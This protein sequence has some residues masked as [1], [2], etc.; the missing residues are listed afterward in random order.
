MTRLLLLLTLSLPALAQAP[1]VEQAKKLIEQKK[2]TEARKL[3]TTIDDNSKDYAAAR[4]HLGRMA[5][6]EE[7]YDDAA[8]FFEEAVDKNDKVADYHNW[9]GNTY[10]SMAQNANPLR[11]GM[12]APKMKSAWEK[13]IALDPKNIEARKSLIEYY[14][15]APGFMGGSFEKAHEVAAQIKKLSPAEGYLA[16][17]QVYA[18]EEKIPEAEKELIAMV[19]ADPTYIGGLASFYTNQKQYD[20]AFGLYEES[21]KKNS[22]DMNTVYQLGRLSA[23]SGQRL[24]AGIELLKKYLGYKPKQNEPSHAGAH[25]RLGN[26][27]EKQGKKAEAKKSYQASLAL[28]PNM[29]E[30]KDGLERV[31]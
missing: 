11:Q 25:M 20:K 15:Q 8:D 5:F 27:Y 4:Y 17:G 7:K 26:I 12:L 3:L 9:L 31:K 21:L 14:T 30:A 13:A 22:T 16:N 23:I 28:D 1:A 29:K 19:K 6:D 18:R 10:G 24:E 2:F